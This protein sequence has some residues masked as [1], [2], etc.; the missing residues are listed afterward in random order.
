MAEP[1]AE[2]VDIAPH[3][4][5]VPTG[6]AGLLFVEFGEFVVPE[7]DLLIIQNEVLEREA[8]DIILSTLGAVGLTLGLGRIPALRKE[9]SSL[10]ARDEVGDGRATAIEAALARHKAASII[11]RGAI[12]T[13]MSTYT[14]SQGAASDEGL[15]SHRLDRQAYSALVKRTEQFNDVPALKVIV[16]LKDA[17][18]R[19]IIAEADRDTAERSMRVLYD[20]ASQ[21][22]A[23]A[24]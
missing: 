9:L 21:E 8:P 15:A 6:P 10:Q 23:S 11:T 14:T 7:P 17:A 12:D 13:F 5:V 1:N 3:L 22:R 19:G 4:T 20:L 24:A 18:R 16:G 2:I